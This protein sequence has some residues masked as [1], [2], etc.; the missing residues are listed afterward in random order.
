MSAHPTPFPIATALR[1]G[2]KHYS[3]AT[4][5]ADLTAGLVVSLVALPLSMALSIAV[6]LPPQNGLYTAI[7]AGTAA[8][9]LGGSPV[10]VSGPTAAFVVIVAPIVAQYGLHGIIWC[11][12]LAGLLLA[13]MGGARLGKLIHFVPYPVT[14]GFTAGIAV[15]IATLALNDLL[16]LDIVHLTGHF[17]DKAAVIAGRLPAAKPADATVGLVTL[18]AIFLFPRVTAKI[19]SPVVGIALGT[20][21][22]QLFLAHGI[23]VDTL[24]T[25]FSYLSPDGA[26]HPGIPPYAPALHLPGGDGLFAW[27]ALAEFRALLMPA[28]FIAA[29]GALESLLSATVADGMARTRHDPNAEL[30]GI[31]IANIFSGMAAGVPATGAIARTSANIHAGAKTPFASA[32]HALLLLVY[33]VT[34]APWISCMPMSALAALLISVAWRMS[35][36]PQF[37]RIL[38][39]APLSDVIVLLTCFSLTILVDMVAGVSVGMVMAS[40]LFMAR[41]ADTTHLHVS[42]HDKPDLAHGK[43]PKGVM[44]YRVEGPLFF[45]SIDKML[46]GADFIEEDI[47]K[48][49]IDLT[50]VPMIDMTGMIGMKTFL[51]AATQGGREVIICGQRAVTQRIRRKIVGHPIARHVRTLATVREAL[52]K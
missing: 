21:L 12:L 25:R 24:A 20:G 30:V 4:L 38:R 36:T 32:F 1:A 18:L 11:Q 37:L 14:M 7:V 52:A 29:L 40:L 26:T 13:A 49:I 51:M 8:A 43:L 27:P 15:T 9:L 39:L 3:R 6:G 23:A 10:Q 2:L 5:R 41:V 47:D 31:G 34:L 45:G 35:H 33:M 28:V 42:T 17:L 50:H 46:D 48:L 16:G 44:I 19:P 22:S